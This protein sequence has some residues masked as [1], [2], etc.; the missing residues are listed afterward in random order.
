MQSNIPNPAEQ[1]LLYLFVIFVAAKLLG[2]MFEWL[3]LP[4]VPGEILTIIAS[5]LGPTRPG[6]EP[7]KPFP[8]SPLQPVNGPV[9]VLVNGVDAPVLYAGGYPNTTGRYQ[10]N[11][12]VPEGTSSGAASLQVLAA[13]IPGPPVNFSIR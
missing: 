1:L 5:G 6:V 2:E 12:R 7:G 4:A 10:M 3:N 13:W 11:F 8:A 9:Q